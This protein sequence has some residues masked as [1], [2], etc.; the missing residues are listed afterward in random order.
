MTRE[1]EFMIADGSP[2][3][4]SRDEKLSKL[5][6][7][8]LSETLERYYKS[9]RPFG[10]ESELLYSKTLIDEFKNGIGSKLHQILEEIAKKEKNWVNSHDN[11]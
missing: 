1:S 7:P 8:T 6:L 3:T 9:L 2:S 4:F 11:W 5:P 10:N